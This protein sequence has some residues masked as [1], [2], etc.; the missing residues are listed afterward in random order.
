VKTGLQNQDEQAEGSVI[1]S[2]FVAMVLTFNVK[3]S[4]DVLEALTTTAWQ[5]RRFQTLQHPGQI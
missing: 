2:I 5:Q 1:Y 3:T 4:L